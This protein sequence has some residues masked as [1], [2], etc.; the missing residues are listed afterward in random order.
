MPFN[1]HLEILQAINMKVSPLQSQRRDDKLRICNA[2]GQVK[3]QRNY[4]EREQKHANSFRKKSQHVEGLIME[5]R[6]DLR[7]VRSSG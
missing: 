3:D 2:P 7:A 6:Y 5:N 1:S 4:R